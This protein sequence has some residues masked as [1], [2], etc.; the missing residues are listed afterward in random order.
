MKNVMI[1]LAITLGVSGS[2]VAQEYMKKIAESTCACIIDLEDKNETAL[3]I[4]IIEAAAPY[5]A[6]IQADMGI[7]MNKLDGDSGTKLGEAVGL[8]MVTVCP[9]ELMALVGGDE[10]V[11][12]AEEAGYGTYSSISGTVASV[13]KG[14][15][16]TI[17]LGGKEFIWL[18]DFEGSLLLMVSVEDLKGA[19]VEISYREA[20]FYDPSIEDFRTYNVITGFDVP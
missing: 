6:E 2:L 12:E 15:F 19:E 17:T 3:G 8:Q 14:Q 9:N 5:E 13:N 7:D 10:M 20:D 18:D 16:Y 11:E 1:I 4:C